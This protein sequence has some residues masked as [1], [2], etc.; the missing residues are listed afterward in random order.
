MNQRAAIRSARVCLQS[1]PE[2]CLAWDLDRACQRV[3]RLWKVILFFLRLQRKW[4]VIFC[5]F[6]I[7]IYISSF[8]MFVNIALKMKKNVL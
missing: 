5:I 6:L 8:I 2:D 4:G 7:L 1:E 3:C